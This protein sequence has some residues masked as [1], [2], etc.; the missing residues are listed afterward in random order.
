MGTPALSGCVSQSC[1]ELGCRSGVEL[2]FTDSTPTVGFARLELCLNEQ[3]VNVPWSVPPSYQCVD[4][5]DEQLMVTICS[6]PGQGIGVSLTPS[7]EISL[8][9]GDNLHVSAVDLDGN[10]RFD[11]TV[12]LSYEAHHPNGEDCPTE[13][14]VARAQF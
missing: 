4:T 5:G 13:C 6:N 9:D 1:T 12:S 10:L 2:T 8:S 3:C 14:R 7:S 11:E